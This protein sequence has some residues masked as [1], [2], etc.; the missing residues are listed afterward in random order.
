MFPKKRHIY[1]VQQFIFSFKLK[2]YFG[3]RLLEEYGS[4]LKSIDIQRGRD[5]GLASYNDYREACGLPRAN[6]WSDFEHEIAP[7]VCKEAV[8]RVKN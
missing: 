8:F 4:D 5:F 2:H 1:F 3:R 7:E 6:C